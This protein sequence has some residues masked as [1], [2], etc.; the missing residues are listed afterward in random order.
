MKLKNTLILL[1]LFGAIFAFIYFFE[2]RAPTTEEAA[3]RSGRVVQFDRDK[4]TKISLKTNDSKIELEKKD[5]FWYLEKPVHDRADSTA[6]NQLFTTAEGLKS[7]TAIPTEKPS[8]GKDPLKEYGLGSPETRLAFIG[9]EKPVEILFGKDAAVEGKSYVR[10]EDSRT[11]HVIGNDLKNQVSKKADEFR[12]H[13]LTDL[14]ATQVDG[15][16]IKSTAGEIDMKKDG[17]HWSLNKPFK[18]RGNDQ[19]INDLVAQAANAHVDSFVAD[20]SNLAAFGLQ[21]PRGSVALTEEGEKQPVLLLFGQPTEKDKEKIY[22]KLSTR[23][24]VL[25]VPRG[26]DGLLDTKPNDV[27]D[28]NLLRVDADIVDRMTI[29]PKDGEKIVLA[30]KGESWVR[31]L[32]NKEELPINVVAANRLL[33]DLRTAQALEFVADIATDLPKYGLDQP[34]VK[35]TLSSYASENTAET[36]A[37]EK[38]IV[39]AL[40]GRGEGN[41]VYAKLD[42]EPFVIQVTK[43]L[44]ESLWTD[45]LQWQ[46][47]FIYQNKPDDLT[48]L[49]V[50]REGQPTVSLER[51]KDKKWVLAKGDGQVNQTNVLSLVNTLAAL[52]AVRWVGATTPEHGLAQP[53]ITVSFK[54]AAGGEGK[55]LLGGQSIDYLTYSSAEGKTGTFGLSTPDAT[56]F[57]LPLVEST[58]LPAAPPA[59]APPAPAP[60]PA[61]SAPP[62]P[63]APPL[64]Q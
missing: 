2:S 34:A 37:G 39:T 24:S 48:S 21:D 22:V 8:G 61:P 10:L 7:E 64:N 28:K 11:V 32:D 55:L 50:A 53:K 14:R 47:L 60:A 5:G 56:V 26:L 19:K 23:E 9:A 45:P 27:R 41:Q 46:E 59:P 40:F 52:R 30:R 20:S 63:A 18:A 12:D 35:V 51:D 42:D 57:Q 33:N 36:K 4:I 49:E 29:Q 13:R 1:L 44:Y 15:F 43:A 25:V 38:P 6:I 54:T 16:K 31:K 17:Q 62:A 3:Q 58:A